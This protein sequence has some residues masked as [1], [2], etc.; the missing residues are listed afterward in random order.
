MHD[1]RHTYGMPS[2]KCYQMHILGGWKFQTS[3]GPGGHNF[4]IFWEAT[5]KV[6]PNNICLPFNCDI[7]L[8]AWF[9]N[10]H[11]CNRKKVRKWQSH[12][13]GLN[14]AWDSSLCTMRQITFCRFKRQL[15]LMHVDTNYWWKAW[16]KSFQCNLNLW[17]L[18]RS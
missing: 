9:Q 11:T 10:I 18:L 2:C 12:P 5:R 3:W 1:P 17:E 8:V 7:G 4:L 14:T 16:S 15:N 6:S 13:S